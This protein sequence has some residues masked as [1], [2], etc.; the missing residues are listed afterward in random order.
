[1]LGRWHGPSSTFCSLTCGPRPP[2]LITKADEVVEPAHT[3]HEALGIGNAA[4]R[5]TVDRRQLQP[6][7]R[8]L[9]LSDGVLDR[10]AH[11]GGQFGL[12][13]VRA[14]IASAGD[15]SAASTVRALEDALIAASSD[16]LEDDA[17]I[18]VFAPAE[19]E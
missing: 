6:G 12:D 19:P 7:Q 10:R 9:L 3:E 1:V 18:V 14:A 15:R 4:R 16:P 2:L 11:A 8:V 17:T 13:G 5:F